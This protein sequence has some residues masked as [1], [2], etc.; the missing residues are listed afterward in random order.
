[1]ALHESGDRPN[2]FP[3]GAFRYDAESDVYVCP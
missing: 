2:F 3:K 1:M